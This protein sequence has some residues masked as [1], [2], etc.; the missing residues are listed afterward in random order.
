[1]EVFT[2]QPGIQLYSGC[3]L[4]DSNGKG[5]VNYG[6]YAGVCFETQNFPNAVNTPNFPDA[7][8]KAGQE[9]NSVTIYKFSTKQL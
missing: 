2:D 4:N 8:L 5:G 6:Q 3:S 9:Y 1:M 7:I